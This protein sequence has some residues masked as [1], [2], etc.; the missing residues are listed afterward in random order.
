MLKLKDFTI[1]YLDNPMGIDVERPR[2]SWK[3]ASDKKDI[4]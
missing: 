3:L 4:H 2:F 1:E